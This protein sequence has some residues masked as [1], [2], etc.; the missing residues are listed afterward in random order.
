MGHTSYGR[1]IGFKGLIVGNDIDAPRKTRD[2]NRIKLPQA[3]DQFT[4]NLFPMEIAG[5]GTNDA[6]ELTLTKIE[7]SLVKQ[8]QGCIG[9]KSKCFGIGGITQKQGFDVVFRRFSSA[10]YTRSEYFF[11]PLIN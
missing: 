5:S 1:Q 7:V 10:L 2:D 8:N 3:S 9:T 11:Q 4:T 6:D